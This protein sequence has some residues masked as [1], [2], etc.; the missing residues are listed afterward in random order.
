MAIGE[1]PLGHGNSQERF[2]AITQSG[3]NWIAAAENV[4]RVGRFNDPVLESFHSWL[5]KKSYQQNMAGNFN[6]TGIAVMQSKA[7]GNYYITQIY[8]KTLN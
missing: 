8:I 6:Y 3:I 7:T 4:A 1:I 5:G 2:A